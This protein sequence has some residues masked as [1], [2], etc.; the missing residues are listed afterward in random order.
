MS[1]FAVK[2]TGCNLP[3]FGDI[4]CDHVD[5]SAF[6]TQLDESNPTNGDRMM[7]FA[8]MERDTVTRLNLAVNRVQN[9]GTGR[10]DSQD[11]TGSAAGD[12][13][14]YRYVGNGPTGLASRAAG[15]TGMAWQR[16]LASQW[17]KK[18]LPPGTEVP[19]PPPEAP[20]VVPE[21]PTVDPNV[22]YIIINGSV[23]YWILSEGS[24]IACPPRNPIRVP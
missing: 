24:R 21:R 3:T 2:L 11:P 6:G 15:E 22:R 23:L 5:Y 9:P 20:P 17:V 13:D 16:P 8:G 10:W 4:A 7:G 1:A 12:V 19:D 18:H 14:L